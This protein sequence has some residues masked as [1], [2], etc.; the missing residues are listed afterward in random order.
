MSAALGIL[1]HVGLA[2]VEIGPESIT[3]MVGEQV[4]GYLLGP[5]YNVA[6]VILYYDVRIRHEGYDLE[7]L[8]REI[9]G[10]SL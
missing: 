9:E 3:A 6:L 2:A 4:L 1:W 10:A 7:L 5:I 8:S